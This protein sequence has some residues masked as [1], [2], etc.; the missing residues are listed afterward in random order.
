M[1]KLDVKKHPIYGADISNGQIEVFQET[2]EALDFFTQ[3]TELGTSEGK[4]ELRPRIEL[5]EPIPTFLIN[6]R[7]TED[8]NS[9][10]I[11]SIEI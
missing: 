7:N 2:Q 3:R 6:E 8:N 1:I 11:M 10:P 5:D 9:Q 4:I